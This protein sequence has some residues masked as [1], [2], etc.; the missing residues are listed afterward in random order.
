MD[1]EYEFE[2]E[3][4][5]GLESKPARH[6]DGSKYSAI[7]RDWSR[8]HPEEP[9]R[10]IREDPEDGCA[11]LELWGTEL[12][13][14]VPQ[15]EA[16]SFFVTSDIEDAR[17][18]SVLME[19]SD[20]PRLRTLPQLLTTA[21]SMFQT[22]LNRASESL[23]VVRSQSGVPDPSEP[24]PDMELS[25][26]KSA[27]VLNFD[28]LQQ[29]QQD[30]IRRVAAETC[31]DRCIVELVLLH[32]RWDEE[33]LLEQ[34]K[35]DANA[36]LA[37]AGAALPATEQISEAGP[38]LCSVCFVDE[39]V[40]CL[41]CGHGL[42]EDDWHNFLKCNLESGT[43]TG[44]NCLHLRCPGELCKLKVPSS[45][46]QRF[47]QPSDFERYRRLQVLSFVN[48]N[49]KIVRCPADGC[50]LCVAFSER[51][52]TVRCSC[53]HVFCFSCKLDAHAPAKCSNARAWVAKRAEMSGLAQAKSAQG[54]NKP[55]PNPKCGIIAHKESGCHYLH[56]PHCKVNWCWQ[57]GDWGGGGSGRPEPHHVHDCNNPVNQDWYSVTSKLSVFD[58]EGKYWFYQERHANHLSSLAFAEKLRKA[59]QDMVSEISAD[60][61][62][63]IQDI[64][65]VK[66]AAEL[67][68]ECRLVLAWTYVW[69][70]FEQDESQRRLFEFVQ[71]DLETKTE[72]LSGM[73]E[74]RSTCEVLLERTK[75]ADFVMALRGYLENI[76]QYSATDS[77]EAVGS[78]GASEVPTNL[79]ARAASTVPANGRKRKKLPRTR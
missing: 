40:G 50:E 15:D 17:L 26:S 64:Q 78:D 30:L 31:L 44:E 46:F 8:D 53:G 54:D 66:D 51:K 22:Q 71:K 21:S 11:V 67:L 79:P 13:V 68:I 6:A 27:V 42:C 69:A 19:L 48:D 65:L 9:V 28:K 33:A 25:R 35:V 41:P 74:G 72:G 60:V 56:C 24:L 36:L 57:C 63:K 45:R 29:V 34:I 2:S 39:A 23:V 77:V 52:S 76:K 75:L 37:A 14:Y 58:N 38:G 12:Q 7:I 5:L 47:L 10:F 49:N 3:A 55:C 73:V 1:E 70:F 18:N 61:R 16:S 20:L 32:L 62:F 4:S 59:V 43:V